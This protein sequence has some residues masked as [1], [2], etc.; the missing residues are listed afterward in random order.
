MLSSSRADAVSRR[1]L[2]RYAAALSALLGGFVLRVLA[3]ALIAVGYGAFLPPWEEWFSGLVPYPQLL[4]SQLAII[5]VYGTVCVQ[6]MRQRGLSV[7]PRR[8][9]GTVLLSVGSVYFAVMVIRYIIRMALYPPERWTGGAIPI[10]FHWVLAAFMLVLGAYHRRSFPDPV[11]RT[12][13]GRALHLASWLVIVAGVLAWVVYLL[14][15]TIRAVIST[16]VGRRMPSG[17]IAPSR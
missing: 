15:P 1:R 7:T 12:G 13:A 5:L 17:S 4:G 6:F 8:W 14:S 3:Q 11:R 9:L 10:F 2:R 16:R